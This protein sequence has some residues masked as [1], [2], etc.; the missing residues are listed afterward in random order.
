M[1]VGGNVAKGDVAVADDRLLGG[2]V[3]LAHLLHPVQLP[4]VDAGDGGFVQRVRLDL[5][6]VDVQV[7]ELTAAS[8]NASKPTV[9]PASGIRGNIRFRSAANASR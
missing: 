5:P 8:V 9:D 1:R 4:F 6:V 7:G 3:S 2:L